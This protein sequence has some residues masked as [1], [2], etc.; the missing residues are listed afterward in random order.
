MKINYRTQRQ[1]K[2]QNAI[3]YLLLVAVVILLAQLSLKANQHIDMTANGRHSLSDTT[4]QFLTQLEGPVR[5]R[6]FISPSSEF[7]PALKTLLERYQEYNDQLQVN[8]IDPDFSPDLVREFNI[9]RQGEMV[10]SRGE[11]QQHVFDLS[12]QSLTNALIAVSREKEQWLVFID[13]HGERTPLDQA[14]F[15]LSTWGSVLQKK[16]FKLQPLNL[17]DHSH[18]PDNTAVL[19]IAS[20]ETAWLD[21]EVEL[22]KDYIANGGHVLWLSEPNSHHHLS[23]LAEQLDLQFLPGTIVDPNTDLLGIADP[24]FTLV[25]NYAQHPVAEATSNVTLFPQAV[26]IDANTKNSQWQHMALLTAADNVWSE[27]NI[28]DSFVL[29]EQPFKYDEGIDPAGPLSLGYLLTRSV[30]GSALDNSEQRLAVIGDGD[31]LSNSYI[32]NGANLELGVALI[33]WLAEDDKLISI[34]VKTTIDNQLVLTQPQSL[35]IGLG[36][37]IIVPTLLLVIGLGIWWY[38]RKQ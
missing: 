10:I 35:V 16:G 23:A 26:A 15:N 12:E 20:P 14:N 19:I 17:I 31:F 7:E 32:G 28:T 36:F 21:G 33:N 22:I 27:T 11:K 4:L 37:L 24:R 9:Q 8:Y 25:N 5:I 2:L 1:I 30:D 34:P 3:F 29:P 18:I 6:A 13:G 38:R